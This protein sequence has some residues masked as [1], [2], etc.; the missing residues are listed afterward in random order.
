MDQ[1]Q[2][3]RSRS[4]RQASATPRGENNVYEAMG[5]VDLHLATMAVSG[6]AKTTLKAR[7]TIII[8][9]LK[10]TGWKDAP[11]KTDVLKFLARPNLT[12]ESRAIYLAH[13]RGFYRWQLEEELVSTDPTDKIKTPRRKRGVPRPVPQDDLVRA[14]AQ[15][16]PTV[17]VWLLL[18][19]FAGL[20]CVEMS[21][22]RGDDLDL[23]SDPPRMVVHGKGGHRAVVPLHP[24]L[25]RELRQWNKTGWLFP[26]KLRTNEPVCASSV[27]RA[28]A[29]HFRM[30]GI[31]HTAHSTRH[32]FATTAYRESGH[33]LLLTRDLLRHADVTTTQV[34][35]QT[36]P[37]DASLVVNALS[38]GLIDEQT[39]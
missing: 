3:A 19:A 13:L 16:R 39:A 22:L 29:E 26:H 5:L 15:A 18:G 2:L 34:Y 32:L 25:A 24:V 38:Y 21:R 27:S 9:F 10:F 14:I 33:N 4:E 8:Q 1:V 20:R 17:R 37:V 31:N 36:D 28:I 30:L 6:L 23:A 35:A 12:E 7:R 11:V